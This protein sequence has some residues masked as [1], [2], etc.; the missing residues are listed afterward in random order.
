MTENNTSKIFQSV[1]DGKNK[2][3]AKQGQRGIK[4]KKNIMKSGERRDGHWCCPKK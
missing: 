1:K 3:M 2:S 4:Q